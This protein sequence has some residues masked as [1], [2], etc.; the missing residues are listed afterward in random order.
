MCDSPIAPG[1]P[2]AMTNESSAREEHSIPEG[3][4]K[5][6]SEQETHEDIEK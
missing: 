1:Q 3:I 5:Y 6:K 2:Q 4:D